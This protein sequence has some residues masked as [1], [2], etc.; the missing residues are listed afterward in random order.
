MAGSFG[1]ITC[2]DEEAAFSLYVVNR[3]VFRKKHARNYS[4]QAVMRGELIRELW[5]IASIA[6]MAND[7]VPGIVDRADS[8]HADRSL[9]SRIAAQRT[10]YRRTL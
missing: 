8:R 1:I 5:R 4:N 6:V 2:R 7:P 10:R 3:L 9:V